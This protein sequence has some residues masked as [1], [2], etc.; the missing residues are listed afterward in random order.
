MLVA[1]YLPNLSEP[2]S[3]GIL[4]PLNDGDHT[5]LIGG[6]AETEGV[7]VVKLGRP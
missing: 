3:D 6:E 5:S 1:T 4:E 2:G 7:R